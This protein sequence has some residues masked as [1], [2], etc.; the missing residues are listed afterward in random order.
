MRGGGGCPG[1]VVRG[2]G[3]VFVVSGGVISVGIVC[4]DE[5]VFADGVTV[6]G[7]T[8]GLLSMC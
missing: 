2:E 4:A 6:F 3:D 7:V 1:N 5:V 8:T